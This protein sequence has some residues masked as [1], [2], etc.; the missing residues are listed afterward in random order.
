M[1][2]VLSTLLGIV[3]LFAAVFITGI[4]ARLAWILFVYGWNLIP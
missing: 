3:V 1:K 2:K 4:L